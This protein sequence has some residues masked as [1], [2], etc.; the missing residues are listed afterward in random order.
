MSVFISGQI[1]EVKK[2]EIEDTLKEYKQDIEISKN[3]SP[4]NIL[5]VISDVEMDLP[6][7]TAVPTITFKSLKGFMELDIN[8]FKLKRGEKIK[9]LHLYGKTVSFTGVMTP[10][11]SKL[12]R[13]VLQMGGTIAYSK[14]RAD[15]PIIDPSA[16]FANGGKYIKYQWIKAL[17]ESSHFIDP[18]EYFYSDGNSSSSPSQ[19]DSP[20]SQIVIPLSPSNQQL[21]LVGTQSGSEVFKLTQMTP[22]RSFSQR[23]ILTSPRP[24]ITIKKNDSN[25]EG[26]SLSLLTSTQKTNESKDNDSTQSPSTPLRPTTPKPKSIEKPKEVN[27]EDVSPSSDNEEPFAFQWKGDDDNIPDIEDVE[28]FAKEKIYIQS[29]R[30]ENMSLNIN[31]IRS[32]PLS[33]GSLVTFTQAPKTEEDTENEIVYDDISSKSSNDT[34]Y[35]LSQDP[36]MA[37]LKSK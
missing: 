11:L 8:P 21:Q 7:K 16:A 32:K 33:F 9:N 35:T 17:H 10:L 34:S 36:L 15:Y 26:A 4:D 12:T 2:Q 29:H 22:E 5:R 37:L 13:L 28:L 3:D 20:R 1:S 14:L 18:S 23:N 30:R 19:K 25:D 31:E 27:D 24:V 6:Q